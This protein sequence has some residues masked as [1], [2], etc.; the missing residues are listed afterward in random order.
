MFMTHLTWP[1]APLG[2][3]RELGEDL[4]MDIERMHGYGVADGLVM[5]LLAQILSL[6]GTMVWTA[7]AWPRN[8]DEWREIRNL[9]GAGA[10]VL[11]FFL[12]AFLMVRGLTASS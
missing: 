5:D 7:L 8:A 2:I 3:Y 10:G 1:A 12:L 6:I 9:V 4:R 11:V